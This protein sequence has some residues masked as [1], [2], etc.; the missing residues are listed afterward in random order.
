MTTGRTK[1]RWSR[2]PRSRYRA[3]RWSVLDASDRGR[4]LGLNRFDNRLFEQL[5]ALI[6]HDTVGP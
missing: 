5:S 1:P 3:E 2:C 4:C 6:E